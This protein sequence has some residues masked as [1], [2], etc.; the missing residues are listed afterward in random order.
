MSWVWVP[1]MILAANFVISFVLALALNEDETLNTGGLASVFIY[2]LVTGAITL[3]D[4]FPFALGLSIRRKDY[5]LGTVL[6]AG[7]VSLCTSLLLTALSVIE[8]ASGGWGVR[9]H[10]FKIAFL[11]DFSPLAICGIY[12]ISLLNLYFIGFAISSIH[13]RFGAAGL[14]T[15]FIVTVLLGTTTSLL[16]GHF[17]VW[18][19]IFTWIGHH[20]LELFWWMIPVLAIYMAVSYGLLRRASV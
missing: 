2:M 11:S 19:S 6:M 1:W 8:D 5:F 13:R 4:T 15:F 12:L 10:I 3:K 7:L 20:Y 16:L 9:L 17:A 18:G 14:I